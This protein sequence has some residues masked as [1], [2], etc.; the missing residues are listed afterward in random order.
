MTVLWR[1]TEWQIGNVL[2]GVAAFSARRWAF[3][4]SKR[5]F[6]DLENLTAPK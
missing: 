5:H 4:I 6:S 2:F 1:N 3:S